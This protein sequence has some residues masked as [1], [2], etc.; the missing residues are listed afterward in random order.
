MKTNPPLPCVPVGTSSPLPFLANLAFAD[1]GK[2]EC[3]RRWL[4]AAVNA[5]K[6]A[7]IEWPEG[8]GTKLRATAA[9]S[10]APHPRR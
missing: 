2:R 3:A 7:M 1:E 6:A 9:M 5:I 4:E 8:P 10:S